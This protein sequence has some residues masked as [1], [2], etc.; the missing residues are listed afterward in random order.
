MIYLNMKKAVKK[1]FLILAILIAVLLY[2]W[3]VIL[4]LK[5]SAIISY[6][7]M[8]SNIYY[9]AGETVMTTEGVKTETLAIYKAKN[10][11]FLIV[12]PCRFHRHDEKYGTKDEWE[13]FFFVAPDRV[14]R[15]NV[16]QGG[17]I[18]FRLPWLLFID[19]DLTSS[20]CV[21]TPS[22][23]ELK[24]KGASVRYDEA[25]ASYV[26]RLRI[27]EPEQSVSFAIPKKLFTEDLLEAPRPAW[28]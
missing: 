24:Q 8:L 18:W 14:I 3:V 7:Y 28:D 19:D 26:F 22:W 20:D 5:P 17:D 6:F 4:F 9:K 21:R 23:D 12:G 13:D 15:T 2:P 10:K 1:I 11:P 27:N 25:T 16:D